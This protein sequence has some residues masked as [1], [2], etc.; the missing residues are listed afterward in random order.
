MFVNTSGPGYDGY[1]FRSSQRPLSPREYPDESDLDSD[2][3]AVADLDELGLSEAEPTHCRSCGEPIVADNPWCARCGR[4]ITARRL[5]S[6]RWYFRAGDFLIRAILANWL[7]WL[8]MMA[9]GAIAAVREY[10]R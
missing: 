1:M 8:A 3:D 9:A 4:R 6:E 5:V 7:F 2:P 10:L